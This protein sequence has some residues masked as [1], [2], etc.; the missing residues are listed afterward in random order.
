[1]NKVDCKCLRSRKKGVLSK[2]DIAKRLRYCND[3]IKNQSG[4]EFWSY[5][6]SLY[7]DGTVVTKIGNDHKPPANHDKSWQI[8]TNHQQTNTN[9]TIHKQTTTKYQQTNTNYQQTIVNGHPLHTKPIPAPGNYKEHSYLK[10]MFLSANF[11]WT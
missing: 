2:S 5:G 4:Q 6:V 7:L 8:I 11:L 9:T 3:K 1:M 10:N